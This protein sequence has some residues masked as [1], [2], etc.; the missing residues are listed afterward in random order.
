MVHL[1]VL[2]LILILATTSVHG[3]DSGQQQGQVDG[4]ARR[5]L[6]LLLGVVSRRVEALR[7]RQ[8]I[9]GYV[10]VQEAVLEGGAEAGG[11]FK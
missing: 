1:I 11:S 3:L 2:I 6:L 5:L 4:E 9:L 8:E 7:L 10:Q